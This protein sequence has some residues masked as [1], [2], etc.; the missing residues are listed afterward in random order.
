MGRGMA[1]ESGSCEMATSRYCLAP[2]LTCTSADYWQTCGTKGMLCA[3]NTGAHVLEH[4]VLQAGRWREG[5]LEKAMD[6]LDCT[7]AVS[8]AQKAAHAARRWA[9]PLDLGSKDC[10]SAYMHR[11]YAQSRV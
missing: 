3:Q 5:Q 10:T 9:I 2:V 6:P 11:N 1:W 7:V 4:G 8:A